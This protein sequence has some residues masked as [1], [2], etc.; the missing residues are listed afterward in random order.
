MAIEGHYM[1]SLTRMKIMDTVVRFLLAVLLLAGSV[2]VFSGCG[3][4]L[5]VGDVDAVKEAQK[6]GQVEP[7]DFRGSA[8]CALTRCN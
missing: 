3:S 8:P 2:Y 7:T 6:K 1:S 5:K 4:G